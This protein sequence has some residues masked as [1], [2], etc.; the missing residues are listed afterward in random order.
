MAQRSTSTPSSTRPWQIAVLI[1]VVSNLALGCF[2]VYLLRRIDRTY[3]SL[4]TGAVPLLNALQTLTAQTIDTMRRTGSGLTAT[5][6]PDRDLAVTSALQAIA[7]DHRLRSETLRLIWTPSLQTAQTE[8]ATAGDVFSTAA[9]QVVERFRIESADAASAHRERVL[10]PAFDRYLSAATKAADL[11]EAESLR[12]NEAI[13]SESGRMTT[14]VL[15]LA[16]W[17][18]LVGAS[19]ALLTTLFIV[20]LML[21]FRGREME[22]SP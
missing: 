17:P 1:L 4:I 6:A 8:L 19:L 13:T 20:V 10:R 14:V 16:S 9:T 2:S 3:S 22:N 18:L 12:T 21:L 15:G 11:L 7:S 5:S